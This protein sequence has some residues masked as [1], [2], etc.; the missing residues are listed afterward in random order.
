M[1]RRARKNLWHAL[2]CTLGI[3]LLALL[4]SACSLPGSN[5]AIA[6]LT[7]SPSTA[8]PHPV[9]GEPPAVAN[10]PSGSQ[11]PANQVKPLTF[12]L[13]YRDAAFDQ[14]V[15]QI[16]TPASPAFHKFL[17]PQQVAQQF[18]PSTVQQQ[19]VISWL[20]SQGFTVDATNPLRSSIKVHATIATIE[21]ALHISMQSFTIAGRT[22]FMPLGTPS[23]S[24]PSAALISS[25]TGLD[26]FA[27]PAFKPPFGLQ[28]QSLT[29][30]SYADCSG[31]GANQN[32][33][34]DRL[35]GA[36][37]LKQLYAQGFKG[38]GMTIGVAEFGDGYDPQDLATYMACAGLPTPNVQNIS[39]NGQPSSGPG[40]GEAIMD[41]ELIAGL[42]PQATILD[43]QT[44]GNTAF[45]QD[46][47][48]VFNRVASDHKVNV[49]SISYG[50][51]ESSFSV[52]EMAAVN[53][54]LRVLAAEGISV[55][56]SSGDCGAYT[57]RIPNVAQVAFPASATYAIA[58]GGTHLQVNSNNARTSETTWGPGDNLPIC[59]NDWGSG[60][61]VS[62]NPD[63]QRPAWQVGPGTTTHFDGTAEHVTIRPLDFAAT[64]YA[65]NGLRQVPDVAAAAY[66]NIS[67][68]Y[69][70]AWTSSG[71]TS[72]AAPIWAAGTLLVDQAL[73]TQGH[74][75][76]GGVPEIYSMVNHP[77]GHHPFNDITSG[78]NMFY[79][80][81]QGWD[82]TTGWG[83]PNFND[84][85]QVELSA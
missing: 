34:R 20:T 5:T 50:A 4:A 56:I 65:P 83:S 11:L 55:F 40:Q 27:L 81:T 80:A 45:A 7:P 13:L 22:F 52:A 66:P 79:S 64:V 3:A 10:L 62:Q 41:L 54:S 25:V 58:V 38:Q 59:A 43:Y 16:Y 68:Y 61:G 70:G 17:T 26:N 48:D 71:G 18:A 6:A 24:D 8:R 2:Q 82:Y 84:I 15:A 12:N 75:A 19:Q 69:Q 33:T 63:F 60:G 49:L 51:Y 32:L 1:K 36:Y 9:G 31:Y 77:A 85:Y 39:V 76:I 37:Q 44:D 53:N 42:A 29:K 47:V 28:S 73:Q 78:A 46:L 23:I 30:P 67:V 35:A 21:R 14:E 57:Q 74:M 72:A